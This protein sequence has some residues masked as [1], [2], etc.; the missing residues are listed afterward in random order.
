MA[1]ANMIVLLE[2]KFHYPSAEE[3]YGD[4]VCM[5]VLN[6]DAMELEEPIVKSMKTI[7]DNYDDKPWECQVVVVL[8][9]LLI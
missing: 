3:G 4:F 1:V 7:H 9:L 6:E 2:H 8:Q 5:V